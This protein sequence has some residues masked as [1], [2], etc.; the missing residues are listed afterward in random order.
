MYDGLRHRDDGLRTVG[1]QERVRIGS[2]RRLLRRESQ[3]VVRAQRDGADRCFAVHLGA[4][5]CDV[6]GVEVEALENCRTGRIGRDAAAGVVVAELLFGT[7]LRAGETYLLA[8]GFE[9]GTGGPVDEYTR[10][11][12]AA[13]GQYVLQVRFEEDA[14]PLR[15]RRFARSATGIPR[16]ER[17]ELALSGRHRTVHLAEQ[18]VRP[19]TLVI[20]WGW[21]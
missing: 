3:L 12:G 4:P 1:H 17:A 19:G 20:G 10:N 5:G 2:G 21:E 16:G 13:G 8:Y 7:R 15:C 11:F 18:A 6:P 14:L 9:D